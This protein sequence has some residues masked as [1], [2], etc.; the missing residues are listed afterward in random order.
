MWAMATPLG[1]RRSA[2]LMLGRPTAAGPLRGVGSGVVCG[3]KL[4]ASSVS[5]GVTAI[6]K[7]SAVKP[8]AFTNGPSAHTASDENK[9]H[10][11]A[12]ADHPVTACCHQQAGDD[13]VGERDG[14]G[15]QRSYRQWCEEP[16]AVGARR[17]Q[18]TDDLRGNDGQGN[19][20]DRKKRSIRRPTIT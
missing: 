8:L 6:V 3:R 20:L 12:Q 17:Q 9:A 15:T 11:E 7:N 1:N 5:E 13:G 19:A 14:A 16:P 18:E 2:Y 4:T 10:G